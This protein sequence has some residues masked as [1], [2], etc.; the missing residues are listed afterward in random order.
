ML[1]KFY[2]TNDNCMD[3]LQI[4]GT[5]T[6]VYVDPIEQ[7][8]IRTA[9]V[10]FVLSSSRQPDNCLNEIIVDE[11]LLDVFV[12]CCELYQDFATKTCDADELENINV[13]L[14]VLKSAEIL[15]D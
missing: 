5:T 3:C 6:K 1:K 15:N 14:S 13:I 11:Q 10:E 7:K 2:L 4:A 9:I 12:A 8:A